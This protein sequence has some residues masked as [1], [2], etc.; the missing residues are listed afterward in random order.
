MNLDFLD[1]VDPVRLARGTDWYY[2]HILLVIR[3]LKTDPTGFPFN[4]LAETI[5][6]GFNTPFS[7][8]PLLGGDMVTQAVVRYRLE[9]GR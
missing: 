7:E 3:I 6:K 5:I 2:I 9:V 4:G 8:L 1:W